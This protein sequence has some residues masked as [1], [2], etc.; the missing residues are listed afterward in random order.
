MLLAELVGNFSAGW[1][2]LAGLIGG[3]AFLASWDLL[4]GA[5]H[6]ALILAMMSPLL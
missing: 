1:A 6:G 4:F 3:V 2:I 5:A